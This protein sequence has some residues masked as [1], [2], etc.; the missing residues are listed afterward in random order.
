MSTVVNSDIVH[1]PAALPSV[2][3]AS[4][5][6][7][8]SVVATGSV[9]VFV[10]VCSVSGSA[11]DSALG[12][13]RPEQVTI[14]DAYMINIRDIA[15]YVDLPA[16]FRVS[17]SDEY[18][19]VTVSTCPLPVSESVTVP[20]SSG[21]VPLSAST[22]ELLSNLISKLPVPCSAMP[23][24]VPLIQVPL[25][26]STQKAKKKASGKRKL[27]D[28]SD[29]II[30]G[31]KRKGKKAMTTP[32]PR[33]TRSKSAF[34]S[35]DATASKEID[36]DDIMR[37][38]N[39][40]PLL[41]DQDLLQTVQNVGPCSEW[42]TAEFYSNLSSDS[43]SQESTLFHKAY[44]RGRWY[45]F[46]PEIINKF[47]NRAA[48]SE[49]CNP[50]LDTLAAALTHNKLT[51][52]PK[53]NL[54]TQQLTTVYSVLFRLANSNWLP[55]VSTSTVSSKMVLLLYKVR[56]MVKFDLG[57]L[58]YNHIMDFV[59]KKKESKIHL[60]FPNLIFG[61]LKAQGFTPYKNEPLLEIP[62]QYTVDSRLCLK[63]H[64]DDRPQLGTVPIL[65]LSPVRA[66]AHSGSSSIP[67]SRATSVL[68][69][70]AIPMLQA[71]VQASQSTLMYIKNAIA[72]LQTA[73][74]NLEKSHL[75]DMRE[76]TRLELLQASRQ[77]AQDQGPA[78][79]VSSSGDDED[80][81]DSV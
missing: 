79:E 65:V 38:C 1:L 36:E 16:P 71:R 26:Q 29:V 20:A 8:D 59:L 74:A 11:S 37:N 19:P 40:I 61:L 50:G 53:G 12:R 39:I 6:S 27:D 49:R 43:T 54:S 24:S 44:V 13:S 28:T 31:E 35:V 63:N 69:T 17:K 9:S 78:Q 80:E 64:H 72:S 25:E 18:V 34:G 62:S 42:L 3:P 15:L 73:A 14:P 75:A 33:M 58:I 81:F 51:A 10:P 60:P 5:L 2:L 77:A 7:A 4:V 52:W 30:V 48:I 21:S 46:S 56:S 67:L 76:L 70:V 68:D 32:S 47:Y 66:A 45:D 22:T 55:T 23:V 57:D 41:K